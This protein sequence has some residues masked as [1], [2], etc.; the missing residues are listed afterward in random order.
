MDRKEK[1]VLLKNAA[2][3]VVRGG[4][5]AFVAV[6]LPPFLT[7]LMPSDAFGAWSLVLQLSA[8]VG[9]LDFG[10]Q[11]AVGR[12]V[13][14]SNEKCDAELRDRIVSTS[15]AALTAAGA[16]AIGAS[17]GIVALL[18]HIFRQMPA[19]LIGDVRVAFLLVAVSLAVGLP[20]SVFNG[21]FV[22]LQR[23][24]VPA[25]VVGASRIV[26]AI[27]LILVVRQGGT[28]VAMGTTVATVNLATYGVQYWLYRRL[29]GSTRLSRKLVSITTGRE[30]SSYCLSLTVWSFATLLVLG[31]DVTLVG[32]FDFRSVAYY[33]V[34]ATVITFILGLQNAIFGALLPVAAVLDA[35]GNTSELGAILVSTTRYGMFLLLASGVPLLL[36]AGPVLSAWV[37]PEYAIHASVILRVLV[38]ANII[39]LSA[40]PYANLLVGT[41]QQRLVTISP[42]VEGFSNLVVSVILGALWGAVGVA[43][44]TVVGSAVGILCNFLYNMPRSSR[45]AATRF[46]YL[47][48][49]YLRPL[50]CVSPFFLVYVLREGFSVLAAVTETR[51]MLLA[52]MVSL[53]GIWTVGL[54]ADERRRIRAW[55]GVSFG[56]RAGTQ[57]Y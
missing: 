9:Y 50:V 10:I 18:P 37:G 57:S 26:G 28:L 49:G 1:L 55:I 39:R 12:F 54:V 30:L 31:L 11:T 43:V 2:A 48:N 16:L 47:V 35:R 17:A 42:L 24:E 51:F 6:F 19:V 22:G 45:I 52:L 21:I 32:F 36:A 46:D 53:V 33:A 23:N 7:R 34:A 5:A 40:V 29:G 25:A 44:G 8:F 3:N 56:S 38:I 13:A 14:H 15:F 20:A 41:G 4:A 27:C